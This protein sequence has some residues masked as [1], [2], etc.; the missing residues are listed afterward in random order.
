[1]NTA[2]LPS[3][4]TKANAKYKVHNKITMDCRT[5]DATGLRKVFDEFTLITVLANVFAFG[6]YED[7]YFQVSVDNAQPV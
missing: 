1:M 5:L 6:T 7:R 3:T 4:N 2:Q